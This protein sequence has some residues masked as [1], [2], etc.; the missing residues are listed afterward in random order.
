MILTYRFRAA[1][2]CPDFKLVIKLKERRNFTSLIGAQLVLNW[3]TFLIGDYETDCL[4]STGPWFLIIQGK[5]G[6]LAWSNC[7]VHQAL[8]SR[9][10]EQHV[11]LHAPLAVPRCYTVVSSLRLMI[12]TDARLYTCIAFMPESRLEKCWNLHLY[13]VFFDGIAIL[14]CIVFLIPCLIWNAQRFF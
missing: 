11:H 8:H 9:Q 4:Y 5:R 2:L 14:R 3:F 13:H 10:T 6:V 1:R 12:I 7:L